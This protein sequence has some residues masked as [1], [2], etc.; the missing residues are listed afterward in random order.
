MTHAEFYDLLQK[1]AQLWAAAGVSNSGLLI[2][3]MKERRLREARACTEELFAAF[4]R[5]TS[6]TRDSHG[7]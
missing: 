6:P 3:D 2:S 1:H 4:Q 7:S 5:A